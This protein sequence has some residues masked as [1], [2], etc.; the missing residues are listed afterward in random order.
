MIPRPP[1]AWRE[2]LVVVSAGLTAAFT[3]WGFAGVV[4]W[5]LHVMLAG[6]LLTLALAVLPMPA[7][8]NGGDGQHGNLLNLRRLLRFPGFWAGGAF[9]V[10]IAIQGLNPAY[11]Q[12]F[13]DGG[14]WVD[15]RPSRISWLPAG[16][17]TSYEP[18]NAFR[19]LA[20]YGAAFAL[21][22]GIWIG[23]RRR[24]SL[25]GLLWILLGN[26]V[27]MAWIAILQHF[28]GAEA[29]LWTVP[30]ENENFWGSFFYRNQGV[31]Y[32]NIILT[33]CAAFYFF[34]F[35]R[36]EKRAVSGGPHLLLFFFCI[37]LATS[38]GLALSRGGIL[39]GGAL[40]AVFL[41]LAAGRWVFSR[42][43]R[44][45][46]VLSLVLAVFFAG[47]S[48]FTARNIDWAEIEVR[49]EDFGETIGSI[50]NDSRAITTRAT[51][52]MARDALLAGYGAGSFR[53]IFPMYQ[54]NYPEI[55]HAGY[56]P[57]RGWFGRR[58]YRYAHNDPV[59][60]LAE[61]GI[62]GCGLLLAASGWWLVAAFRGSVGNRL[63]A[64][65]LAVGVVLAVAHSL[66]DFIFHSPA[67]TVAFFALLALFARLL[68]LEAERNLPA[69]SPRP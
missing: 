12:V 49:F 16:V 45:S 51:W 43:R 9:L 62:I 50:E 27:A 33:G 42:S 64:A 22:W 4:A 18:M 35:N 36:A 67:Y 40:L 60:F 14:W 38:I 54:K 10:Y 59:Q 5:S 48:Y 65:M 66:V 47:G 26:G 69:E 32:L 25:I 56:H 61:Y 24:A 29:V 19:I 11:E 17:A 6:G 44:G 46:I 55:Y 15:P 2:W 37:I 63:T 1:V 52:D 13:S 8:F 28:T 20:M 41:V 34:Y 68:D 7:R 39:F 31:A 57:K 53:Y 23:V 3:A 30:S 21:A 58:F